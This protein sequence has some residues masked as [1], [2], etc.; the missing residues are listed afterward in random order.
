MSRICSWLGPAGSR[1][2]P[3]LT[4]LFSLVWTVSLASVLFFP[5]KAFVQ[6]PRADARIRQV[7]TAQGSG[8]KAVSVTGPGPNHQGERIYISLLYY[9]QPFVIASVDPKTGATVEMQS[10]VASENGARSMIKGPDGNIYVGT[11][12]HAH[13]MMVDTA[14]QQL[15][16][17][18]QVAPTETYVWDLAVGS[19]NQIYAGTYPG[20][21]LI[22]YNPRSHAMTDLGAVDPTQQYAHWLAAGNDGYIYVGIGTAK[23]NIGAYNISNGQMREILPPNMQVPATAYV[24]KGKDGGVYAHIADFFVRCQDGKATPIDVSQYGIPEQRNGLAGN[25]VA[26]I[27]NNELHI[28][29]LTAKTSVPLPTTG[30][31]PRPLELFRIGLGPNGRLYGSTILPLH[32]VRMESNGQI[33]PMGD[34]G[35]GEVYSFLS[36]DPDL[37]IAAYGANAPLMVYDPSRPVQ[38]EGANSNPAPVTVPGTDISW[39]PGA[40]IVGAGGT[41]YVGSVPTYGQKAG[42]ITVWDVGGGHAQLFTGIVTDQ[43]ITSLAEWWRMIVGG[44]GIH[45]GEGTQA[46][47]TD[48]K[49]FVWDPVSHQKLNEMIPVPGAATI[50]DLIVSGNRVFGIADRTLFCLSLPNDP[51][52]SPTVVFIKPIPFAAAVPNSIGATPDGRLWGL[53]TEGIFRIDPASGS[54]TLVDRTPSGITGG[55]AM[56]PQVIY[57]IS[58][59]AIFAYQIPV[60]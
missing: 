12:P 36:K 4:A 48:A 20:A 31:A 7:A 45:G 24:I 34:L 30:I 41:V 49:V 13:L 52:K 8:L 51:R 22:R 46:T 40:M 16:D 47:Q 57:Y 6:P 17:L 1:A 26:E 60:S 44:T 39:R 21:K 18:G 28:Q 3:S 35:N 14:K 15:V 29:D 19:D 10:P 58:H 27:H 50:T 37:L 53:A 11:L 33:T 2:I 23:A 43:S 54:I 55:F 25:R 9:N 42:G 56:T 38:E 59:T 5:K 32:L